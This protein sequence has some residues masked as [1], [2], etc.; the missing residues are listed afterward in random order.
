MLNARSLILLTGGDR[1]C[2][3]V[4]FN[5]HSDDE[6]EEDESEEV[7]GP[8]QVAMLAGARDAESSVSNVVGQGQPMM[9]H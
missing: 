3:G 7:G 2:R 6:D 8:V 5:G 4:M 9:L 1:L